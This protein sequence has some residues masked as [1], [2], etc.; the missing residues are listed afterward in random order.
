MWRARNTGGGTHVYPVFVKTAPGLAGRV[1]VARIGGELLDE[2]DQEE[3]VHGVKGR[4]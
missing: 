1:A 4:M 3:G 2:V